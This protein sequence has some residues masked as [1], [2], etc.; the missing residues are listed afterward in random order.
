M[1]IEKKLRVCLFEAG[2]VSKEIPEEFEL[3]FLEKYVR[4]N[5]WDCSGS[6]FFSEDTFVIWFDESSENKRELQNFIPEIGIKHEVLKKAKRQTSWFDLNYSI[7]IQ[8]CIKKYGK[9][10]EIE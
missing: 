3:W 2:E 5:G 10:E 6:A 7:V 8:Y 9:M 1:R 4:S